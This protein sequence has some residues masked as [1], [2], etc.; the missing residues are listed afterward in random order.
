MADMIPYVKT[1]DISSDVAQIIEAVQCSAYT[2]VDQILVIRNWLLG[3]RISDEDLAGTTKE[4][5][6]VQIIVSLSKK[7]TAQYGK[8]FDRTSLYRFVQFYQ[9]FPEI[10][11]TV[12]PQSSVDGKSE[13]VAA[14]RQQSSDS[15][16]NIVGTVSPQCLDKHNGE[17]VGTVR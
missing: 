8:G 11:A 10:V 15:L 17:I 16:N 5:Y 12:R 1:T 3:K 9:M 7:L 6:G 2:A 14:V 13:I 4:R